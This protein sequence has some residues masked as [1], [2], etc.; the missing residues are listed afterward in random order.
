[1]KKFILI[2]IIC[3]ICNSAIAQNNQSTP[4]IYSN[5]EQVDGVVSSELFARAQQWFASSYKN[6]K[7]VLRMVDNNRLVGMSLFTFHYNGGLSGTA[8]CKIEYTITIECRDGRYKYTIDSIYL[9]VRPHG[10]SD[11]SQTYLLTYRC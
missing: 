11:Y 4:I 2:F 5:V 9:Y 10:I 7:Q 3:F 1:M 8:H 6:S